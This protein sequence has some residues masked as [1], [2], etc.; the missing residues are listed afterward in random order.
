MSNI[1]TASEVQVKG[2]KAKAGKFSIGH[3]ND[4]RKERSTCF[5]SGTI[6]CRPRIY[7]ERKQE[8][9][10]SREREWPNRRGT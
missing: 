1:T 7:F 8:R 5:D 6:D 4:R 3:G 9:P 10:S 2:K